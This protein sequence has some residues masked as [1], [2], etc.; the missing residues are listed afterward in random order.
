MG[1]FMRNDAEQVS[2]DR[3]RVEIDRALFVAHRAFAKLFIWRALD[4]HRPPFAVK[5]KAEGGPFG[6]LFHF[7]L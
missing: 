3:V 1:K 4:F 7:T 2:F 5:F 6:A